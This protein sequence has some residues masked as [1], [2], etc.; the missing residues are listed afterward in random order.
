MSVILF[1]SIPSEGWTAFEDTSIKLEAYYQAYDEDLFVK[2]L[3]TDGDWTE[4]M[5]TKLALFLEASDQDL[6][7]KLAAF[8]Q[9]YDEDFV[10]KLWAAL[11]VFEDMPT[12]LLATTLILEDMALKLVARVYAFD[13]LTIKALAAGYGLVDFALKLEA[14]SSILIKDVIC[15]FEVT[16]GLVFRDLALKLCAI[17]AVPQ[18]K[19]IVAQ[20]LSSV[21]S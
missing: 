18:Y 13:D 7:S 19:A 1:S 21:M 11:T 12:K 10:A 17:A 5:V 4:D 14:V 15:K 3:V 8:N 2:K 20:R 9:A 6:V 16:D